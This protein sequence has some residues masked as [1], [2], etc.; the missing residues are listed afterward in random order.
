[1]K[2]ACLCPT[3]KRPELLANAY[4]CF[5]AQT[6]TAAIYR[7][8]V[9]DD[10]AQHCYHDRDDLMLVS[11][12]QRYPTLPAKYNA[13]M[14]L[15][16]DAWF[17]D[18]YAIWED[19]DVFL[20]DHLARMAAAFLDG[21]HYYRTRDVYSNY[22]CA[23]DGAVLREGAAG[24]FHSSW[25]MT[26]RAME[27]I[28]G[29]P[30]SARLTFDQEL[31]AALSRVCP[32]GP[33][34]ADPQYVYRWGNGIYHGSQAG[35][36]GYQQLWDELGRMPAPYVGSLVPKFDEETAAIYTRHAAGLLAAKE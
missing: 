8:F 1:M 22:M 32:K 13:L 25:G 26:R 29:Y 20:P 28:G 14:R 12:G 24:R 34:D 31:G 27:T 7:L 21:W 36:G 19:D 15:A 9:I 30:Q 18:A 16:D 5:R 17:P 35:D 2:I 10:A 33:I 11:T 6:P 4:A 23:K 3:Y